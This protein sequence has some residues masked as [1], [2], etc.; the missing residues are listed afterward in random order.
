[1]R[2]TSSIRAIAPWVLGIFILAQLSGL[3]PGHYE[4]A[5]AATGHAVMHAPNSGIGGAHHHALGNAGDECCAVHAMPAIAVAGEAGLPH[6]T[7]AKRLLLPD[8]SL[9]S[10]QFTPLDPP[11][12]LLPSI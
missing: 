11:P 1:M 5:G 8:R 10:V 6:T 3:A 9:I 7:V 2:W 12:K 4:H